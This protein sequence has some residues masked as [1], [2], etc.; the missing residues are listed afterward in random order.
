MKDRGPTRRAIDSL[1]GRVASGETG[2]HAPRTMSAIRGTVHLA[3]EPQPIAVDVRVEGGNVLAESED[4][5]RFELSLADAS[6]E[7]GGFDGDFVFCRAPD[8]S[9]TIAVQDAR[10]VEQLA[11]HGGERVLRALERVAAHRG[12]HAR[13][14]WIGVGAVIAVVALVI[15]AIALVP[16][17]LASSTATLPARIDRELGDAAMAQV[18]LSGE[19]LDDPVVLA[20]LRGVVDRL[21]PSASRHDFELRVHLVES[22]QV[23][24]F[25]LPGGQMVVFTGLLRRAETPDQVAGVL[26]HEIAH[27]TL[28]HGIRNVAHRAGLV[29][30]IQ[31]LLGDASGWAEL[32]GDAAVLAQ[33]NGYS[34]EQESA[35]DAEGARM[36]I[37]SGLDPEGMASFFR[38]LQEE[39]GSDVADAMSWLSTHPDLPSRVAHIEAL[40]RTMAPNSVRPIGVD[41]AAVKRAVGS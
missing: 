6:L 25:A 32:A 4:G 7:P 23:N 28:R 24:A 3:G 37:A 16:T 14:R 11:A 8:A 1:L 40:R 36:M 38:L 5:R 18:E 34:R 39:P 29:L 20:F 35:A 31:L 33:S 27:V 19:E 41:W 10:F 15:G 2:A 13:S 17:M 22:E 26:A 21:A 30:A 9:I 12:R